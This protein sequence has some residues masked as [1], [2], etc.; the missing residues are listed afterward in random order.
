MW[1]TFANALHTV[2]GSIWLMVG[3]LRN[4]GS[5]NR[6]MTG[7]TFDL[8]GDLPPY[9]WK[10]EGTPE[11]SFWRFYPESG[12]VEHSQNQGGLAIP[13]SLVRNETMTKTISVFEAQ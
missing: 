11:Q 10:G 6:A 4:P 8:N 13:Q 5:V 12:E 9:E 7:C 1:E 3:S 2:L